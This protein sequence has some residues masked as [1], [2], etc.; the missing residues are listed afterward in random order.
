M[1][2]SQIVDKWRT[3]I[4]CEV[5]NTKFY[6]ISSKLPLIAEQYRRKSCWANVHGLHCVHWFK[7]QIGEYTFSLLDVLICFWKCQLAGFTFLPRVGSAFCT[8]YIYQT[9]L[10]KEGQE[11]YHF[12]RY[13]YE[14]TIRRK[15]DWPFVLCIKIEE[16][17]TLWSIEIKHYL[18]ICESYEF[19]K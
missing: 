16:L 10:F 14:V 7:H 1:I 18:F 9:Y 12:Y 19:S 2:W 17:L 5:W 15:K 6:H 3:R 11:H 8:I 13:L 4:A